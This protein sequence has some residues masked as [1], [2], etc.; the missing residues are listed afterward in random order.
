M[1]HRHMNR[2]K[3]PDVLRDPSQ[4][5]RIGQCLETPLA[6]VHFAAEPLP[7]RDRQEKLDTGAVGHL[8]DLNHLVP[9]SR[10]TLWHPRERQAAISIGRKNPQLEPIGTM[11]RM[12]HK[13]PPCPPTDN[14]GM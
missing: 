6:A 9:V 14:A 10:P 1:H 5:R 7:A 8:R 11:H 4:G 12:D 13:T 2:G 3:Q